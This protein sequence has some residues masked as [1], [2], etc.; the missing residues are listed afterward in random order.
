MK[1][2]MPSKRFVKLEE[3]ESRQ[4]LAA[5]VAQL[6]P[7]AWMD[8]VQD[9]APV[10][11][12]SDGR[13]LKIVGGGKADANQWPGIV[14]LTHLSEDHFCGGTLIA[15]DVVV[16]AA[17]C[18]EAETPDTMKVIS[19]R[20]DLRTNDGEVL[21]VDS[22]FIHRN[23]NP[24][25]NSGDIAILFLTEPSSSTPF[26]FVRTNQTSLTAP[27]IMARTAGWGATENDTSP[28]EL[29]D[30][31]VPII[32]NSVANQVNWLAGEVSASML[33][34]GSTGKDSC[35]GDSGGPLVVLND[36]GDY[37]L[38][39]ITS[40]GIGC[41][42]PNKPGVYTRVSSYASWIE[43][44]VEPSSTGVLLLESAT[45]LAYDSVTVQVNDL[46]LAGQGSV[47]LDVNGSGGDRETIELPETSP[48]RFR[49]TVLLASGSG[50]NGNGIVEAEG[51][52]S[53][54]FVYRDADDGTGRIRN[55]TQRVTIVGDDHGSE[56]ST[57][58]SIETGTTNG[59]INSGRDTDWFAFTPEAGTTYR[60]QT[61]LTSLGDSVLRMFAP[62]G[63]TKLGDN[64]DV[65]SSY[66]SRLIWQAPTNQTVYFQVSGL[67][68]STGSFRLNV[69]K[70]STVDDVGNG[71]ADAALVESGTTL[72]EINTAAEPDW[73]Q[74]PV[75]A[76]V[77]YTFL[78]R[79]TSLS[80]SYLR[81]FDEDGYHVLAEN[82]DSGAG[83]ASRIEW[84]AERDQV[85]Y[86]EVTGVNGT[87]GRYTL[88][89][90]QSI[91]ADPYE[92]NDSFSD[93]FDLGT[94]DITLADM[95][96]H[97]S[98]N[99]D[100]FRWTS[101]RTSDVALSLTSHAN[102]GS[103]A[104]EVFNDQNELLHS[105]P[106]AEGLAEWTVST[107][108]G[109]VVYI[110]V[111]ADVGTT[112][113]GYEFS[114]RYQDLGFEPGDVNQDGAVNVA[115]VDELC[116][117]MQSNKPA[118]QFDLNQDA[119]VDQLD[120]DYLL[121]DVLQS[122]GV[123]DVNLDG[124]FNSGDL[125]A[126]FSLGEYEDGIASN[127]KWSSGDWNCDGEFD[128]SDFVIAF[129]DGSY[130]AAGKKVSPSEVA[131]WASA[132]QDDRQRLRVTHE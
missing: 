132:M 20:Y 130:S 120:L 16:T 67:L 115:D 17:H 116:N 59:V 107:E 70:Y 27:G 78:T 41:G 73:F 128:S 9:I 66:A 38:A 105:I 104:F 15:P 54:A 62:D 114:I 126:V 89:R 131:D 44:V 28:P 83:F 63:T 129:Q 118:L 50:T 111:F 81:L 33:A 106:S 10:A 7:P 21:P 103:I 79:L 55:V 96:I 56:A 71:I 14:A 99:D 43:S 123:G 65:G 30:V 109:Q 92:N 80:D 8:S 95:T 25:T 64:D 57:A 113:P 48:G 3:L 112:I 87:T 85:V 2:I 76:G 127:S 98:R 29:Y 108:P 22:I 23:W 19:G 93:A 61:V 49:G 102:E 82:D 39:G 77:S 58:T 60:I 90:N 42:E 75:Y 69:S 124:V 26:D 51:G 94:D 121:I 91:P 119:V 101:Q 97:S 86:L 46:D 24:V 32:S 53:V 36:E 6:W 5:D 31:E 11:N 35:Q 88:V 74:L 47:Q 13:V 18:V 117:A 37:V 68:G 84:T 100:W 12:A 45:L 122:G 110:R 72:A 40:W 34:A 1:H 125:V 52:N 4:L